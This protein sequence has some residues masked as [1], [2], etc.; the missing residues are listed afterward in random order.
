MKTRT[1]KLQEEKERRTTKNKKAMIKDRHNKIGHMCV[2]Q[3][4]RNRDNEGKLLGLIKL[5][6]LS[7][8]SNTKRKDE[9][10]KDEER[11]KERKKDGAI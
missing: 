9:N 5:E 11:K 4:T 6:I 10:F 8:I 1:N 7:F 3:R 2:T